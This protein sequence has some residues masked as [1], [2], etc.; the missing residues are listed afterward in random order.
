M[1]PEA[2]VLQNKLWGLIPGNDL[3]DS[4]GAG[5]IPR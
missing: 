1:W 2:L 3:I 4:C 5:A